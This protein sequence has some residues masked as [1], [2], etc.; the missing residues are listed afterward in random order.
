MRN[1]YIDTVINQLLQI[2]DQ[3]APNIEK[4]ANAICDSILQGGI[5]QA[6]GCGHSYASAIEIVER[7]G[8]LFAAKLIKDP[9]LGI[10]ESVE[11]V[12]TI[13][14]RK[15]EVKP[16]DTIV[17]ISH[18]GR[19]PMPIEVALKCKEAGAT[20]ISVTALNASKNLKSRHSSGK[21]L[22]ELSD[23]VLDTLTGNGDAALT[24]E[25]MQ[26]KICPTSSIAAAALIQ[27]TLLLA[28]EKLIAAG[29]I[30][31]IRVSANLDG[32]IERSLIIQKKYEHR[33]HRL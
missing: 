14:M 19:N 9:A 25:G 4:A 3:Q 15:V 8:G 30:P 21:M 24:V 6:F 13:L 28:V 22:Y 7:A 26:Q 10:Y 5:V 16:E 1:R 18:S 32:G 11:G 12:G 31:D 2:D 23:I 27:S 17:I 29:H 33:I 20:L